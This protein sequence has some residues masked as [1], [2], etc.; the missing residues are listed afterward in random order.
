MKLYGAKVT[1]QYIQL[2][3]KKRLKHRWPQSVTY[4]RAAKIQADYNYKN[5][6]CK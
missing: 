4:P 2:R 3:N 1:Q 5:E 6:E